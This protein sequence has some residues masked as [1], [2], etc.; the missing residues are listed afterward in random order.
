MTSGGVT[1]GNSV[2][3]G[4]NQIPAKFVDALA[5][6]MEDPDQLARVFG[7]SDEL[8]ETAQKSTHFQMEV[9]AKKS[10]YDKNGVTDRL[11]IRLMTM[12][13]IEDL[14]KRARVDEAVSTLQL[15]EIVK[16]LSK[17]ADMEPKNN[18]VQVGTS[19][20]AFSINI[21]LPPPKAEIA[22]VEPIVFEMEK[23]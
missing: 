10:E 22:A 8:W 15:N 16:T 3:F 9:A 21:I 14:Y 1:V 7:L 19:G 6:G 4:I 23:A 13:L 18:A 11:R 12:D 20:P 2:A 5:L 17:L